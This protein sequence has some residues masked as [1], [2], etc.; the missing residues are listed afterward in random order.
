MPIFAM[1]PP[2]ISG[3]DRVPAQI[4]ITMRRGFEVGFFDTSSMPTILGNGASFVAVVTLMIDFKADRDRSYKQ[5]IHCAMR[6]IRAPSKARYAVSM[7]SDA[8]EPFS[9][10][11]FCSRSD[12]RED[13]FAV[14]FS[15]SSFLRSS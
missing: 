9:A 4:V 6:Q 1:S 5:F 7:P 11:G 2:R 14:C 12:A 15:H 13:S 3:S 10:T 8:S